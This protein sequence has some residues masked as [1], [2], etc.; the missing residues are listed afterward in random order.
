MTPRLRLLATAAAFS[1]IPAAWAGPQPGADDC[2]GRSQAS[3][4]A[5][6]LVEKPKMTLSK[7]VLGAAEGQQVS[8]RVT[9]L[10]DVVLQAPPFREPRGMSIHP[11]MAVSAP[12][13]HAAKHHPAVVRGFV[14]ALPINVENKRSVQDKKTGAWKGTGEG[15][16][17]KLHVNDLGVFL[18]SDPLDLSRPGQYFSEPRKVG[19][20][21]GFPV[22]DTGGKEV[23]LI[24]KRDALPWRPFPVESYLKGLIAQEKESLAVFEQQL[25]TAPAAAKAQLEKAL[26]E[27]R[28]RVAT[29]EKELAQL[30]PAQRQAGACQS[31]R[32]ASRSNLTGLDLTCAP[33]SSTP[34]VMAN[35]DVFPR[36]APKG[37]F[38]LLTLTTTW[39]VLPKDDGVPNPL[40][41]A[42]RTALQQMDLKALQAL[43]D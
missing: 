21:Q 27:P 41:R 30:S 39:G 33:A 24:S 25:P 34:L 13:D 14:L 5:T 10:L 8:A 17:M 40:G 26:V 19:E 31:T 6:G 9:K 42:M 3:C 2:A 15:P 22:Y 11:S 43:L 12:P 23:L 32:G 7:G 16:T 20:V 4:T 36:S 1:L 29:L 38:Q 37:S 28:A 18:V 35:Q